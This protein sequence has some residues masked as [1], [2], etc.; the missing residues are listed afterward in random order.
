MWL[1]AEAADRMTLLISAA[2]A[3]LNGMDTSDQMN[4][5]AHSTITLLSSD[6]FLPKSLII[7]RAK[8]PL[9]KSVA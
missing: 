8:T 6:G 2:G 5:L 7:P 4:E 3:L 9:K 1:Y